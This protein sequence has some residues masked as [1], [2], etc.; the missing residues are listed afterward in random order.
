MMQTIRRRSALLLEFA[1]AQGFGQ[2]AGMIS[3][4]IFVR[5]MPTEEYALYALCM[6]ALAMISV[7]SD[8]GLTGSLGY[9]WR[10]SLQQATSFGPKLTAVR[11]LRSALFFLAFTIAAVMLLSSTRSHDVTLPTILACLAL[12]AIGGWMQIQ[13][14]L[15]TYLIRLEGRQRVSYYGESAG[16]LV[17]L[18]VA[19]G[20]LAAGYA[21]AVL[22]VM[23]GAGAAAISLL[24]VRSF[25]S[26]NARMQ[27]PVSPQD[28]REIRSYLLPMLPSVVMFMVQDPLIM[29][30]TSTRGGQATVA[31]VFALNRI[32]A[33][34]AL[35]G[36]FTIVVVV[37]RLAGISENR[38]FFR[39][40]GAMFCCLALLGLSLV[41]LTYAEPHL[42]LMLIGPKYAHLTSEVVLV[43]ISAAISILLSLVALANRIRGWVAIDPY[44]AAIQ[45][46]IMISASAFWSF[47]SAGNV[48]LLS[49]LI[50][51]INLFS[52]IL[53]SYLGHQ[54]PRLVTAKHAS[55]ALPT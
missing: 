39:A 35:V 44:V 21:T 43:V 27:H 52:A 37:P 6:T 19:T 24:I 48:L 16:S 4:L 38:R 53:I 47:T 51:S 33:V 2:A 31:E 36:T 30:L 8:L 28:R 23:G 29:Y 40:L 15:D 10:Q 25:R 41:I 34:L 1:L 20:M 3:G 32:A 26:D 12:L 17:R 55:A 50:G 42:P 13:A 49:I 9:F 45:A 14:S 7:G 54:R 11:R 46:L 22:G 18:A 5:I